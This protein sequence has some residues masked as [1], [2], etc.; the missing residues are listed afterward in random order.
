MERALSPARR[1][2]DTPAVFALHRLLVLASALALCGCTGGSGTFETDESAT[3][4]ATSPATS[5][6]SETAGSTTAASESDTGTSTDASTDTNTGT[7][8]GTGT[9]GIDYD[10]AGPHPVANDR[11]VLS[12]GDREL[13]VELWYPADPS[14]TE[15]AAAGQSIAEFVP[16]GPDREAFDALLADLS[17]AGMIGTRTQTSA[18]FAAPPAAGSWPLLVF[19]HCHECVRFSSYS[20]AEHLA[21][22]GFVVAA[23]DHAGNTL[24]DPGAL[25]SDEFLMTRVGD[26]QAVLDALTG[27]DDALPSSIKGKGVIDSSK[28]GAFGHSYGAATVGRLAQEDARILA[29]MPIAAPVENPIFPGTQVAAIERPLLFVR[30]EEDNS[31][32]AIG[33]NL[34]DLNFMGAHPPV[35]LIKVRDA[36]HWN[37]SDICGL[38]EHLAAGCGEGTRQTVAGEAFTYLDIDVARRLAGAYALA[39]F[40]LQLRGNADA[41]AYLAS[42]EPAEWVEVSAR[43]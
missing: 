5:G 26:L 25:L 17:P 16:E 42:P 24:F 4:S 18:A 32:L 22:H 40:D 13:L 14:A 15:A 6:A 36:G 8:T 41:A 3:T 19:S 23:P 29:A 43:E 28:I 34:I 27:E 31:I 35:W 10:A 21:S 39:F 20:L 38:T 2:V 37:F 12:S 7:G 30:A 11:F 9:P 33:N 1:I